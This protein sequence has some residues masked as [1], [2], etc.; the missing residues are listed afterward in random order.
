MIK[1]LLAILGFYRITIKMGGQEIDSGYTKADLLKE[2]YYKNSS[3]KKCICGGRLIYVNIGR[4]G[5]HKCEECS[6]ENHIRS[7]R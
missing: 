4:Y 2:S 5:I 6:F 3:R 7:P 1:L